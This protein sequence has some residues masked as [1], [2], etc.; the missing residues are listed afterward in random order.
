M[1]VASLAAAS[2][3]LVT[4]TVKTLVLGSGIPFA[5]RGTHTLKG[6][7]DEWRLFAVAE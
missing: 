5:D 7:A 1:R 2:E 6:V 3:V 4:E